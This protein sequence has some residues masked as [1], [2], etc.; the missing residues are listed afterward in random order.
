M[1]SPVYRFVIN[2]VVSLPI[3]TGPGALK[4]VSVGEHRAFNY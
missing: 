1:L 2:L 4:N 3:R